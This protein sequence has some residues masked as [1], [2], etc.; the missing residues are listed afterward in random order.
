MSYSRFLSSCKGPLWVAAYCFKHLKK[1]QILQTHIPSSVDKILQDEMNAISYRVLAYLL[2]GVVRIYSK[3]AEY[4]LDDCNGMLVRIN[5]F[6]IKTKDKAPMETMR[7]SVIIPDRFE[8]DA[9]DLDIL[10]DAGGGHIASQEEITLKD[11]VCSNEGFGLF[12]LDKFEKFDLCQNIC[13]DDH[14][15]LE[16]FCESHEMDVEYEFLLPN[17]PTNL[18]EDKNIS[19]TSIVH[20]GEPMNFDMVLLAEGVEKEPVDLFGQDQ[21]INEILAIHEA[22]S[23]EDKLPEERSRISRDEWV[24]ASIFSGRVKEPALSVE[25]LNESHQVDEEQSMVLETSSSLCQ[26]HKESTEVHEIR[27][28]QE[29]TK[30][31][32]E[33]KSHQIDFC[34]DHSK[35]SVAEK[36][37]EENTKR[38]VE[39]HEKES[40][41]MCQVKVLLECEKL[42]VISAESK[43][44]DAT[45]QSKLQG[46]SV[47]KQKQGAT[48]PEFMHISTP[49]LR[50][51]ASFSRK[52]KIVIDGMIVVPNEVLKK[53]L[54][55]TSD[56]IANRRKFRRT[57]LSVQRE[58]RISNLCDG[59]HRPLFPCSSLDLCSLFSK[60]KISSSLKIVENQ[61][62]LDV[63]NSQTVGDPVHTAIAPQTPC[64]RPVPLQ[65]LEIPARLDVSENI[66]S[67]EQIETAPRTP[68]QFQ[69]TKLRPIEQLE[70]N[71]IQHTDNLEPSIPHGTRDREQ[72]LRRD[73]ELNLM[74]EVI[75]SCETENSN[76]LAGWSDRTR[77][78]ARYLHRSY[79]GL[80][81]QTH[82]Q[83][84]NFSQVLEGRVR[85]ECARLFYELLVLRTTSYVGVE[86]N[87]A[88]GDILMVK[89]QKLDQAF[90]LIDL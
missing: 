46:S 70:R 20:V 30:M 14:A 45:P 83:V 61:E 90:G 78:V 19:E 54:Y 6:V 32:Q 36:N 87:S 86:Q 15:M 1:A 77:R 9:F 79:L 29:N 31:P 57:L 21:Q 41:F 71:E 24:D 66:G 75:N 12:S 34:M 42:K 65:I 63:S 51:R 17:S 72:P 25:A 49:A 5:K 43:N 64:Q 7:M 3:K 58:S 62:N 23:C 11:V 73:D 44:L 40:K 22:A 52:R 82:E 48:S 68:P 38:S 47:R 88:Y 18:M 85:K 10:E 56:L 26:M 2:L 69:K 8:L 27:N 67:P 13:I 60:S 76:L 80:R 4:L 39:E 81:K 33:D 16:D 28:F 55:D 37:L 35:S 59:F 84:V 89:L 50:E 74:E 53:S